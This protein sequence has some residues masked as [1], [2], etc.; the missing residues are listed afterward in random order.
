M[1]DHC[2]AL[3][4][5]VLLTIFLALLTYFPVKLSG[6]LISTLS[7]WSTLTSFFSAM[8]IKFI[9]HVL[10][11]LLW[12]FV[13]VDDEPSSCMQVLVGDTFCLTIK[14]KFKITWRQNMKS[15]GRS[16]LDYEGWLLSFGD[17][18]AKS[19]EWVGDC[20]FV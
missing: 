14:L 6:S 2:R 17:D 10:S 1:K 19:C 11:L 7:I 13:R 4:E 16:V 3:L 12:K 9:S 5:K 15:G 20:F 18:S 8:S